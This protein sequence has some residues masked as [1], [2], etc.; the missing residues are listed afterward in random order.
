[1]LAINELFPLP[2]LIVGIQGQQIVNFYYQQKKTERNRNLAN[3]ELLGEDT[4]E[5]KAFD[6]D[7]EF[8]TD[9]EE[10]ED[11]AASLSDVEE[12]GDGTV[13]RGDIP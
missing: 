10:L 12:T 2:F 7:D 11:T 5:G 1:M 8:V 9:E 13:L 3:E 6:E 4:T